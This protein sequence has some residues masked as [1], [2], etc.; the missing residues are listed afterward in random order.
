MTGAEGGEGAPVVDVH[1]HAMPMPVL[2]WLAEQGLADLSRVE[3]N[4]VVLDPRISG[5][6]ANAPLPLARS[7]HDP[8]Q[9]LAEMDATGVDVELVS[10]PPFLFATTCQDPELVA[11]VVRRGN[12]ALAQYCAAAP[13]RLLPLGSVP[14]G[15]PGAAE[16]ALRALDGL[17]FAGIAIGS[18][19]AGRDL[20]DPV[21]AQLWE[22]LSARRTFVFLHPSGVPDPARL[23][24]FWF[25][26]L[27][28]YPMETAIAAAR[29]AF[30]GVLER[31][32]LVLCL[33]HGGG[34]LGD[35]RSRLDMG[36]ERKPVAHTTS[37]P[38]SQLFDRL[39]YDTAVFAPQALR[40]LVD[41]VGAGQV[42]LGTDHPFDLAEKDPVG[43]VRSAGLG[44]ETEAAVLGATVVRLVGEAVTSRSD[45][46]QVG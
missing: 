30:G 14:L 26:Q 28:G 40:H 4:V 10:L 43:F 22:L 29:L 32:P 27:V 15:W 31:T 46:L 9:R 23:G 20:D 11:E 44:A 41:T 5:V 37:V 19:G 36:W 13:D 12:D 3:Q 39:Y 7:M 24:D 18:K 35:L 45:G 42:L 6:G 38:P 8:Q 1:A 25:P 2:D 21:N 17:G 34:C 16:E 33:A